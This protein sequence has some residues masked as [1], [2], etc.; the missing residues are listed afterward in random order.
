MP[1]NLAIDDTLIEQAREIG[2]ERT[3]KAVVTQALVEYINKRRQSQIIQLFGTIDFDGHDAMRQR[4]LTRAQA[5][6]ANKTAK[7]S[8]PRK[9]A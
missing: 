9:P 3:K 4:R 8:A 7:P 6:K 5:A 1:T 2:G